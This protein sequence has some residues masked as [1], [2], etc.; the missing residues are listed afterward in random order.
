M[1]MPHSMPSLMLN[2]MESKGL[3]V[4][5]LV[6]SNHMNPKVGLGLIGIPSLTND[7]FIQV[8]RVQVEAVY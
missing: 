1:Q 8:V 2:H 4:S 7:T 5:L 6:G 3:L